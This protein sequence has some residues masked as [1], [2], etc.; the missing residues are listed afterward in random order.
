MGFKF[1]WRSGRAPRGEADDLDDGSALTLEDRV[2]IEEIR[3]QLDAEFGETSPSPDTESHP[4]GA[5][6]DARSRHTVSAGERLDL[7][8]SFRNR[9]RRS[10]GDASRARARAT[11]GEPLRIR[12]RSTRRSWLPLLGALAVGCA[13]GA[14]GAGVYFKSPHR[15]GI[16]EPPASTVTPPV[17]PR[18]PEPPPVSNP[19][20]ASSATTPGPSTSA[21]APRATA[22]ALPPRPRREQSRTPLSSEIPRPSRNTPPEAQ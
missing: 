3:R 18:A 17:V 1:G 15:P 13:V 19:T 6:G 7:A 21:E 5:S 22:P 11:S 8:A 4:A 9:D 20:R 10:P 2:G 16:A 12:D 14:V